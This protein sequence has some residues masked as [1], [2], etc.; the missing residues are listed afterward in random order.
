MSWVTLSTL[1][2][3][4]HPQTAVQTYWCVVCQFSLRTE[5]EC[6][7]HVKAF[8]AHRVKAAR[9]VFCRVCRNDMPLEKGRFPDHWTGGGIDVHKCSGSGKAP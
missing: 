1:R 2:L 7:A 8:P 3:Q 6:S 4:D 9:R 5:E